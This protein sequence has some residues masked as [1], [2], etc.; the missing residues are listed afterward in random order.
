[1]AKGLHVYVTIS[2]KNVNRLGLSC[3][4]FLNLYV[5]RVLPMR[6]LYPYLAAGVQM[7]GF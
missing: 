3:C 7:P 2:E 5:W 4:K 6:Q 1:M